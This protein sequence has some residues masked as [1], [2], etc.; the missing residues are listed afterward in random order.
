ML[1]FSNIVINPYQ[2]EFW[3]GVR[4][5][6]ADGGKFM[7]DLASK[8]NPNRFIA[9]QGEWSL[10]WQQSVPNKYKLPAYNP[11]FDKSFAVI[12]DARALEI[13]ELINKDGQ[14]FALMYSGGIDSTLALSALIKN[15]TVDELENITICANRQ[16]IV[17]N[18]TFWKKFVWGKFK[19]LDS[20]KHKYDDLI[21][22]GLRPITADEGD[23]LFGMVFGIDFYQHTDYYASLV[24]EDSRRHLAG[25]DFNTSH[26]SEYKDLLLKHFN[27]GNPL[28]AELWY[29]KI[30]RN[31]E[32]SS[33]PVHTIHDFFWWQIFNL[34]YV[35]CAMRCS[36]YLNDRISIQDAV[37]NW[38]I[39]WF[40]SA[41]YQQWSMVNN[42]NGEKIQT[43]GAATYKMAS[44]KYIHDLDHNDWYYYFK[45]KIGS[46]GSSVMLNQDLSQLPI[47]QRPNARFGVDDK[48]NLL[49]IDDPTVQDMIKNSMANYKVDWL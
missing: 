20:N 41:D 44:R 27:N 1:L 10:P 48:Y 34:K 38:V 12:T 43:M 29:Q 35:N 15:L 31:I 36:I 26:Y 5:E 9:R 7:I 4:E 47:E 37:D 11:S 45:L 39:N 6:A 17:E 42:N 22:K 21:E 32:T 18:P 24:S 14:E 13:K 16:S 30:V 33:V 8:Y 3:Q 23:C 25:L 19:L 2:R 40:N 28:F 49:L 46:L